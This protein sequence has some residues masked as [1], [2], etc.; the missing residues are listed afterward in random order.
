MDGAQAEH[1]HSY[2]HDLK[3]R[4]AGLLEVLRQLRTPSATA[5]QKELLDFGERQAFAVLQRT[6]GMLDELNVPRAMPTPRREPVDLNGALHAAIEN[7]RYRFERKQQLVSAANEGEFTVAADPLQLATVLEALLSNASKFSPNGAVIT[8]CASAGSGHVSVV[9]RDNG[10]GLT[11]QD[12]QDV[13]VRYA[14]LGSTS[15][16]GETQGRSTLAHCHKIAEAH[17]GSLIAQSDGVGKGA[18]FT[19]RLPSA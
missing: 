8:A 3:N 1:L 4:I 6:D 17:G 10:V 15:T 13:F 9:V 19:L 11:A 18:C 12:V 2:A 7:Q 5:E 16:A 14:W